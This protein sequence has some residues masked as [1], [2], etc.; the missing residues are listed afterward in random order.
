MTLDNPITDIKGVG[1][2]LADRLARLGISTVRE[3]LLHFPRRYEDF[4][5]VIPIKS[6]QPG[7]VT[8]KGKIDQIASRRSHRNRRLSLTEAIISDDTGTIKAIW[9]NQPYLAKTFPEGSEVLVAGSLEFKNNDLAL[10]SPAIESVGGDPRDTA[11]IV[12]VYPE[13]E[14]ITSKQLRGMVMQVLSLADQLEETLPPDILVKANLVPLP[15][16]V[17]Q[18][19]FPDSQEDLASARRRLAFEE[20]WYLILTGLVIKAEIKTEAAPV[21]KFDAD[22]AHK[23][24]DALDFKLTDH[25]RASAWQIL[26]D[27]ELDRPMNRL[28]E[29]DVGS[30]KTVVA[31]MAAVMAIQAGYQAALMVPTE[32]LARQHARKIA[33]ILEKLGLKSAT[34]LGRQPA[35]E[36]KTSTDAA[37]N[38]SADLIIGTH[39]LLGTEIKFKNLGLVIIDEQHRFG[40]AQRQEL[41]TKAAKMPHLLSMTATPIPRSLALTVYGDLDLSIISELPPG[42]QPIKT[43]VIPQ[44]G[45]DKIYREIDQQIGQG[46]QVYVICP[47]IEESDKL[48]FKSA[49][50]EADRLKKTVFKHRRIG[51]VHGRLSSAEKDTVMNDFANGQI[52][53]LVS[54]TVIEVGIDVPNATVM[55]IEGADRFG[56]ASLHQLRGRVGRGAHHSFCYLIAEGYTP[57]SAERLKAME[58]TNDGFRLAQIDLELRGPGQIYGLAQHGI[59]DLQVADI[60]D[61]KLLAEVKL[62]ATDFAKEPSILLKYPQMLKR[63]N[64]LKA[65]T[66]LD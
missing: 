47:L 6:M 13:T 51:L 66:T 33:P 45:R 17:G 16:A 61:T 36:K 38:G 55:L 64:N 31:L 43:Q 5:K 39:A 29:G 52:D 12:P 59:L 42:R 4:S 48:G 24:V 11:R 54:T 21:I 60:T 28:L 53:I 32:V 34:I 41:K 14:G 62:L 10:R 15:T 37:S 18:I 23:Y 7:P 56:L 25:Q 50:A 9:F 44:G 8:F 40:V 1:A 22:L 30:G 58:R 27:M 20:L 49:T 65:V 2:T 35:A 63:I 57:G 3:L 26:Q 19:H 46:R